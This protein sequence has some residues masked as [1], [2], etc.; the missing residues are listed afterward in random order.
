M[1]YVINTSNLSDRY[2]FF[3]PIVAK[4]WSRMGYLP[5]SLLYGFPELWSSDESTRFTLRHI[6]ETSQVFYVRPV[7]RFLPSDTMRS[8]RIFAASLDFFKDDDYIL[9]SDTDML[10]LNRDYFGRQ[11]LGMAVH[12]FN[13]D[14]YGRHMRTAPTRFPLC[15]V[16]AAA[17][18]WN[19][20]LGVQS[21]DIDAELK[22]FLTALP[23]TDRSSYDEI[24]FSRLLAHSPIFKG[25]LERTGEFYFNKGECQIITRAFDEK[26]GYMGR[27]N[28]SY[29]FGGR[30]DLIDCHAPRPG[31][32]AHVALLQLLM[33]YFPG[34]SDYWKGYIPGF[35]DSI[36]MAGRS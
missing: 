33:T 27:I 17:K 12:L 1:R 18:V 16:G 6:Q 24:Y 32:L 15:Y 10:P 8:A 3:M 5:V 2:Y 26:A 20:F 35:V 34:D 23:G 25:P 29:V 9:V 13:G 28:R 21:H 22:K 7:E 11:D 14:H 4:A 30:K 31:Y 19:L 36:R